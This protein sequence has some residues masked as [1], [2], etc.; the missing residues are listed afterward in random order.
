MPHDDF[1]RLFFFDQIVKGFLYGVDDYNYGG[2]PRVTRKGWKG[3]TL[4]R[5]RFGCPPHTKGPRNREV[6]LCRGEDVILRRQSLRVSGLYLYVT[7]PRGSRVRSS[8]ISD[9]SRTSS[10]LVGLV[11]GPI[12]WVFS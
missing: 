3:G 11:G 4:E 6:K 10:V 8:Q 2:G 7:E 12:R 5:T 1:S 9:G